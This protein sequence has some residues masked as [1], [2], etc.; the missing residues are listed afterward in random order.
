MPC[1]WLSTATLMPMSS[2]F[3]FTSGPPLWPGLIAA[4]VWSQSATS[5][6]SFSVGGRR[7]FELRMPLLTEPPRPKGFPSAITVSPSNRSSSASN[8]IALNFSPA[9]ARMNQRHVRRRA[10][11]HLVRFQLAAV[12]QP[13]PDAPGAAHDVKVRHDITFLIDDD[14]R[15]ERELRV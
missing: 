3:R 4:S 7:V 2:P 11:R 1:A 10:D 8:R 15:A 14:S 13:H 5:R 9:F 6:G 12:V